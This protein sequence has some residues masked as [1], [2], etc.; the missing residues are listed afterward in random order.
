MSWDCKNAACST[1]CITALPLRPAHFSQDFIAEH[2][3]SIRAPQRSLARLT[4]L[5]VCFR[6]GA[7]A[8][9]PP[10]WEVSAGFMHWAAWKESTLLFPPGSVLDRLN[11]AIQTDSVLI[12]FLL[13]DLLDAQGPSEPLRFVEMI[14]GRSSAKDNSDPIPTCLLWWDYVV[15]IWILQAQRLFPQ[16]HKINFHSYCTHRPRSTWHGR[17]EIICYLWNLWSM[18]RIKKKQQV[19]PSHFKFRFIIVTL[20]FYSAT[21]FS[22]RLDMC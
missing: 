3:I 11:D 9:P 22:E 7:V 6:A 2:T 14:W 8:R 17:N 16:L 5:T 20:Q 13:V 19:P 1:L 15:E 21:A 4:Y 18:Y 10:D 12:H